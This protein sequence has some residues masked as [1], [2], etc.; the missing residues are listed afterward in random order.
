M[1]K[2]I[3][4]VGIFFVLGNF[5]CSKENKQI[6]NVEQDDLI[7]TFKTCDANSEFI[8]Y[9]LGNNLLAQN[10]S[11]KQDE[12]INF[13][14]IEL[15]EKLKPVL[16]SKE[17]RKK[18]FE[19]IAEN[20]KY[21]S[22]YETVVS[23]SKLFNLNL[24][25]KENFYFEHSGI[26]YEPV[27][28][29]PNLKN[30]DYNLNPI[31]SPGIEVEDDDSKG[32]RDF[33]FCW[34]ADCN[35]N[36]KGTV[37]GEKQALTLKNPL[38][39]ITPH[40]VGED[41][42]SEFNVI[43]YKNPDDYLVSSRTEPRYFFDLIKINHRYEGSGSSE[44]YIQNYRI[45]ENEIVHWLPQSGGADG[46]RILWDMPSN[47]VGVLETIDATLLLPNRPDEEVSPS[48]CNAA[49]YAMWER[50]WYTSN[51]E[52]GTIC[53]NNRTLYFDGDRKYFHEWYSYDPN[54][55]HASCIPWSTIMPSKINFN[56][57]L[58]QFN[59]HDQKGLVRLNY[60]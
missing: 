51:K 29:I 16:T 46:K 36:Y 42:K 24:G 27:I 38:F 17:V 3:Y 37:I 48:C 52:L 20:K 50:D 9:D 56:Q 58:Q 2:L 39:V 14:L 13:K 10:K 11:D 7:E 40:M 53:Y 23:D 6:G 26:L 12:L 15:S 44:V 47:K 35:Y 60:Q 4:L 32:I 28:N 21:I 55:I 54:S 34:I 5:S 43:N 22:L 45:D 31:V 30:A 25:K 49:F 8:K 57:S 1:K 18:I 33:I 19:L 59:F 41:Y